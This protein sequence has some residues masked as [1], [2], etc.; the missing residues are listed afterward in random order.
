MMNALKFDEP[1]KEPL[2]RNS[3]G[4]LGVLLHRPSYGNLLYACW[5]FFSGVFYFIYFM[6][7]VSL[8]IGLIPLFLL[9]LPLFLAV[10]AGAGG[11]VSYEANLASRM[12][13]EP[14]YYP[15]AVS[16]A[17][18]SL[19]DR[20]RQIVVN[21]GTYK[22]LFFLLLKFPLGLFSI[23]LVALAVGGLL[24]LVVAITGIA[25]SM[26][27]Q[28]NIFS[29]SVSLLTLLGLQDGPLEQGLL[30]IAA[31]LLLSMVSMHMINLLSDIQARLAIWA[32]STIRS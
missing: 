25:L 27:F 11:I 28:V 16:W 3:P 20:L 7:G 22:S 15:P 1:N 9:G 31:G 21:P 19:W 29:G 13:R 8:S 5:S 14:T 30:G 6:V 32:A 10:V 12:L 2:R 4:F 23:V 24:T 18:N 26:A 17:G